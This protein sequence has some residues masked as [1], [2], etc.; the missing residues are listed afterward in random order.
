MSVVLPLPCYPYP[1]PPVVV[2]AIKEAKEALCARDGL[3]FKVQICPAVPGSPTRVLS[4]NGPPPFAADVAKLKDW[5]DQSEL[6]KWV[7]WVLD[8]AIP[9]EHGFTVA[10]WITHTIPGATELTDPM[11]LWQIEEK[12]VRDAEDRAMRDAGVKFR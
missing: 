12:I 4:F 10:D 6:R 11:E 7:E 9:V 1:V 3:D 5:H 2:Q 8:D